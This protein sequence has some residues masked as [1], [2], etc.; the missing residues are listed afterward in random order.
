MT[1]N[2][3]QLASEV[4]ANLKMQSPPE[5]GLTAFVMAD[6]EQ[7]FGFLQLK[8][9]VAAGLGIDFMIQKIPADHSTAEVISMIEDTATNPACGG[10]IV[11]LPLAPHLNRAKIL[12][13]IPAD[14][15]VDVMSEAARKLFQDDKS[16]VLPPAAST[17]RTI[18]DKTDFSIKESEVHVVGSGFL[19]GEPVAHWL[20]SKAKNLT[21]LNKGDDLAR[22][23]DAD[24]IITATGKPGLIDPAQLKEGAAV[25]D[26]GYGK[27]KN[28]DGESVLM[29][30]L[31]TTDSTNLE[32]LGFYT[33]TP[34]GTGPLLVAELLRN[35]Y[36]LNQLSA[37]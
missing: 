23:N 30:D 2:G 28:A 29:G 9:K 7:S 26:F 14:K 12:S 4:I 1:I 6:N 22:L 32:K 8:A 10:I 24:L 31:D 25:I 19:T 5:T 20:T 17:T 13:A 34:G 11:Q 15:D 35:F 27:T 33:P 21:V 36:I 37:K 3:K 18:L 16:T